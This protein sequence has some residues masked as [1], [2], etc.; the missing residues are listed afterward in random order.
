MAKLYL[1]GL[2]SLENGTF[3]GQLIEKSINQM[4]DSKLSHGFYLMDKHDLVYLNDEGV[5]E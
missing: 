3:N 4:K 2:K 1:D 5:H